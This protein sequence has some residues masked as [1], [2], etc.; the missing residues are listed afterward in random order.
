MDRMVVMN[1]GKDKAGLLG[2]DNRVR[3]APTGQTEGEDK[4]APYPI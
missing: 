3:R 4:P 2:L 1:W